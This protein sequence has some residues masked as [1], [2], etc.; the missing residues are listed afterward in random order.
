MLY[1]FQEG[2][3][4]SIMLKEKKLYMGFVEIEKNLDRVPR[5]VLEWGMRKKLVPEV[6]VRSVISL[7][8]GAKTKVNVD[9]ELSGEVEAK[10][11]KH[12]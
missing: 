4:K 11:R 7:Y 6:R 9:S 10:V 3:K 8:E 12:K 5:I 2:C 1:L